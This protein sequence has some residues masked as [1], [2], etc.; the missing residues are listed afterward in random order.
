[1]DVTNCL[2]LA[3]R[4][5]MRMV[6]LRT[7]RDIQKLQMSSEEQSFPFL[8]HGGVDITWGVLVGIFPPIIS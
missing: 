2:P 4:E 1:M 3:D 7:V 5:I 6:R 8:L